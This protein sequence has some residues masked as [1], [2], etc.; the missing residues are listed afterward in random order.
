MHRARV[1][2]LTFF[3]YRAAMRRT[4][5]AVALAVLL[6]GLLVQPSSALAHVQV[7]GTDNVSTAIAWSQVRFHDGNIDGAV[8]R[9]AV[10]ARDDS[11]ADALAAGALASALTAPFLVTA[12]ADL[13]DR[14]V[15]ELDRLETIEH[16]IIIGGTGAVST[17]VE[18]ALRGLGYDVDRL[19]G[20]N[21]VATAVAVATDA[22][23]ADG[24]PAFGEFT[25]RT[26]ARAFGDGTSGFADSLGGGV[27]AGHNS[28]PMLVTTSPISPETEEYAADFIERWDARQAELGQSYSAPFLVAGGTAAVSDAV[29]Q[30]IHDMGG[31]V[32]RFAGVNRFATAATIAE[33]TFFDAPT[34]TVALI[35]GLHVDSW[36]SGFAYPAFP[37]PAGVLLSAG[38]DLPQETRDALARMNGLRSD[39][40]PLYCAPQVPTST[41]AAADSILN[42]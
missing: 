41:C 2:L 1:P 33:Q 26:I 35:D 9:S 17:A 24:E 20:A 15:T 27:M 30:R 28:G 22:R 32:E 7:G 13:D 25:A 29:V 23:N 19:A 40:T 5:T 10:L 37:G 16:V 3:L 11:F 18:A 21:R 31:F 36:V 14:V 6:S 38:G 12:T 4:A 8:A 39:P 42:G 34:A